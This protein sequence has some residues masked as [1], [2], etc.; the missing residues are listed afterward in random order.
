MAKKIQKTESVKNSIIEYSRGVSFTTSIKAHESLALSE[1]KYLE[2]LNNQGSFEN[3]LRYTVITFMR[4]L[5][6]K[7]YPYRPSYRI[8]SNNRTGNENL[9]SK[10][11]NK[12]NLEP[13]DTYY[14][15][16]EFIHQ[17]HIMKLRQAK[18]ASSAEL[19]E[20]AF[21]LGNLHQKALI[22]LKESD[23]KSK[24]AKH[25]RTD[26]DI[27][28]SISR[29]A[30]TDKMAKEAFIDF[31]NDIDGEEASLKGDWCVTY[32]NSND[33]KKQMMFKTFQNKLS[34]QRRGKE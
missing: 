27:A 1:Y 30:K 34:K 16:G 22:F 18:G 11:A 4:I 21:K 2:S 32:Y 6:S 31:I 8:S 29:L 9:L 25:H 5:K 17:Y 14:V 19:I 23:T 33:E 24:A 3:Q 15:C 7:N 20:W 12:H 26:I 10:L 13:L 28:K